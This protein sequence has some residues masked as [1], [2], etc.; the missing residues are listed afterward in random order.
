VVPPGF[1]YLGTPGATFT[2]FSPDDCKTSLTTVV[3]NANHLFQMSPF[4]IDLSDLNYE[5]FLLNSTEGFPA[6]A[7]TSLKA[8]YP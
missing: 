3:S 4:R 7:G 1:T 2:P 5:A 6:Y 8:I